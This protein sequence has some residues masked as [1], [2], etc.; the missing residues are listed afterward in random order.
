MARVTTLGYRRLVDRIFA[1]LDYDALGPI[2]CDEGGD[3]F[4]REHRGPARRLGCEHAEAALARLPANG[5]SLWVGAGVSE[6]PALVA[7]IVE[8]GREV[9]ACNLRA[10]EC[11]V[12]GRAF[13][14][15]G[16]GDRL[17]IEPADAAELARARTG[18][19]HLGIVSVL[20]DPERFP[21]VSGVG[22]GRLPPV[23][24]DVGAF[25]QE[26][27]EIL[28]LVDV[29]LAGLALPGLVTTSVEEVPWMLD[30]ARRRGAVEVEADE[31]TLPTAIVGDGIGFLRVVAAE[32]GPS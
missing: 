14:A 29:C 23:L 6:I 26:R 24:L 15:V 20:S 27:S 3:A 1:C 25:E 13:A 9:D 30:W 17:R 5:R 2:Y 18:Y 19:D 7:E 28:R 22:Y 32:G 8:A 31:L 4:W 21:T 16:L 11:A 12:L 10:D